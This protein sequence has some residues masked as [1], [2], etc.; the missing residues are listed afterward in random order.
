ME[1][2]GE[3]ALDCGNATEADEAFQEALAH[4]SGSVRGA[5][6]MWAVCERQGR[7]DEAERYLKL[8][9]KCWTRAESQD[10]ERL[11]AAMAKKAEKI[12]AAE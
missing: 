7:S 1:A 8:A 12:T 6:G 5:L 9:R 2:W 3:A 10:F 11:K 4:D